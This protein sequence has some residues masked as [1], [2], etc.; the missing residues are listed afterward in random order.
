MFKIIEPCIPLKKFIKNYYVVETNSNVK[1]QP[2]ERIFPHGNSTL[3]FHYGQP[4]MFQPKMNEVYI[5]PRLLICG[6]QNSY[7]DL[8]LAGNTSMIFMVFKPHGLKAFFDFP[9]GELLNLNISLKLLLKEEASELEEQLL[10]ANTNDE[11]IINLESFLMNRL[12]MNKD[13]DRIEHAINLMKR[14]N[15]QLKIQ[16]LAK[17]T[18][19][20]IKQFEREFSKHVGL[21]PKKF[22]SILRFQNIIQAKKKN[23]NL[24]LNH[25]AYDYGYYDQSHFIHDFKNITGITPKLFF[26]E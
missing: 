8:S 12:I 26:K 25:L 13:F 21:N 20:G 6:Q 15:G 4:S 7:Y 14:T 17:E 9:M 5:E 1:Y 3:L 18:C 10:E 16:F 22:L 19:L 11:R 24:N 23:Q 2:K